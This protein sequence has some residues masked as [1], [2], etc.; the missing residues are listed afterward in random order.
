MIHVAGR[1]EDW[2]AAALAAVAE[3][4]VVSGASSGRVLV[5]D[6]AAF[7]ASRGAMRIAVFPRFALD[8]DPDGADAVLVAH[9]V[10]K[11]ALP[12]ALR[13]RA[14]V[15][16]ALAPPGITPGNSDAEIPTVIVSPALLTSMGMTS[17]LFQLGLTRAARFL[18]DVGDDPEVASALRAGLATHDLEAGLF[19]SSAREEA[20]RLADLALGEEYANHA[21]AAA[22]GLVLLGDESLAARA[23]VASGV[24]HVAKSATLAV[25]LDEAGARV[26]DL[27]QAALDQ[28]A[29]GTAE[30]ILLLARQL[31]RQLDRPSPGLPSGIEWISRE[32][33]EPKDPAAP[34]DEPVDPSG[35]DAIERELAEL[36]QRL[37]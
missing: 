4:E 11:A 1:R 10:V 7:D 13:V 24:A 15:V 12:K 5:L 33:R 14:T 21:L 30:R 28:D 25:T 19:A 31:A 3:V 34:G 27:R 32:S 23:L 20:W 26:A 17:L 36:K 16:G 22:T 6:Q 29:A 9:D 37:T 35:E 2:A 18:F 8:W